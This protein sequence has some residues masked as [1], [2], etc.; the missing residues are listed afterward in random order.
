M[1]PQF[2]HIMK[3]IRLKHVKVSNLDHF[4]IACNDFFEILQYKNPIGN[5]IF[6]IKSSNNCCEKIDVNYTHPIWCC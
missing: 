6:W 4:V 3:E 5:Y 1:V 2:D